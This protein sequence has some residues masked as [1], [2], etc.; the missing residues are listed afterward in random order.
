M[1]QLVVLS[2][3]PSQQLGECV[4]ERKVRAKE[5]GIQPRLTAKEQQ[6]VQDQG[7]QG[8]RSRYNIKAGYQT[9]SPG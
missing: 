5:A 3:E 6:D 7:K 1:Y 8:N 9:N 4:P 2:R